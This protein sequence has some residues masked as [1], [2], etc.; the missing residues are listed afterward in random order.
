[1][2]EQELKKLIEQKKKELDK[3]QVDIEK[4]QYQKHVDTFMNNIN[5]QNELIRVIKDNQLN[6]NDCRLFATKICENLSSIYDLVSEDIKTSQAR[7]Q[8]MN[9]ARNQRRA[10]DREK[11]DEAKADIVNKLIES[12]SS[13]A[14]T[15][16]VANRDA[17]AINITTISGTTKPDAVRQY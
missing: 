2:T 8:H 13:H 9:D 15:F 6:I 17:S 14:D 10:R 4:V 12:K 5:I 7:R 16:S 1:M 3:L 11:D